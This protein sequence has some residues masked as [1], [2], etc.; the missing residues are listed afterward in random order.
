MIVLVAVAALAS[1]QAADPAQ[2][3]SPGKTLEALQ[4]M[5]HGSMVMPRNSGDASH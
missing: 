2:S 3:Q 5:T 1:A 4:T